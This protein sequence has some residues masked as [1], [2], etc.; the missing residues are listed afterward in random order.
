MDNEEIIVPYHALTNIYNKRKSNTIPSDY[1]VFDTET[2][3]LDPRTNRVIELS[4]IK[5]VN[6]QKVAQFSQ[7]INPLR[8]IDPFI[9][10]LTGISNKDLKNQPL[11]KDVLNDFYLFIEDFTL[12]AHN[13]EFDLK[14]LA[15]EAYRSEIALFENKLIDTVPLSRTVIPKEKVGNYKLPTLKE[16]FGL[17]NNSHRAL[18]DCESCAT[19]YQYYCKIT[20]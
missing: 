12:V 9:T 7:L 5:Y 1:I 13:A 18:D 10:N 20:K 16:Y 14:M 15:A 19:I 11:V 4:A 3:G 2:T 6:H 17:S 8:D